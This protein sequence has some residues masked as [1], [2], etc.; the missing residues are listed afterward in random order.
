MS[1]TTDESAIQQSL[2]P[3]RVSRSVYTIGYALANSRRAL[4]AIDSNRIRKDGFTILRGVWDAE[5]C[6]KARDRLD[7]LH[8]ELEPEARPGSAFTCSHLYN[9]GE[10]FEGVYKDRTMLRIIRHFLGQD[11][12]IM[13][14]GDV[15]PL[16]IVTPPQP[17]PQPEVLGGLHNDGSLTGAF[18][19]VGTPADECRRITSHVLYLQAIWCLSPF[20]RER[21]GTTFVP[22]SHLVEEL[23]VPAAPV[24]GQTNVVAESG[25]VFLYNTALVSR[26]TCLDCD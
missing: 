12:T 14:L 20:D 5:T 19:G 6:A 8:A 26:M 16:G 18:Q 1:G 11:A 22:G 25:D 15:A 9:K 2:Q 10:V 23:P 7:E 13:S 24:P 3:G 21:G 17:G 4:L